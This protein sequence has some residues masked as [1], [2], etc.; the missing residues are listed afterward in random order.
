LAT[1]SSNRYHL[2]HIRDESWR[3]ADHSLADIIDGEQK[4]IYA[5]I[6]EQQIS[7]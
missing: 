7:L 2:A 1:I 4:G 3:L 6:T 5:Q